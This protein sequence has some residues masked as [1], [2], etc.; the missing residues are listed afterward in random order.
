VEKVH[1][2]AEMLRDCDNTNNDRL[3]RDTSSVL[4]VSEELQRRASLG[5]SDADYLEAR[6]ID[7]LR[8]P[9]TEAAGSSQGRF[10]PNTKRSDVRRAYERLLFELRS[11]EGRANADLAAL[12]HQEL[13]G[14]IDLYAQQKRRMG[15]LDFVDLLLRVRDLLRENESVRA[16]FRSEISH[17]FVDEFQDTDPIQVEIL[18]LLGDTPG[19]L[20][21]VGDPKQ[22]IYRFRRADLGM[23]A[24]VKDRLAAGGAKIE[25]LSTSYRSLPD[26][27]NFVNAAFRRVMKGDG[28]VQQAEYVPLAPH[29]APAEEGRLAGVVALPVPE[30]YGSRG[31]TDEAIEASLPDLVAAFVE[32][33]L[34][35][36][37]A[38]SDICIL[39][40]RFE[41]YGADVTRP[42]VQALEARGIA[43]LLVGG[44]SFHGREEIETIRTALTAVEWPDDELSLYAT[45]RGS[46]FG[47][48]DEELLEYRHR[49]GRL[50]PFSLP[51]DLPERLAMIGDA[52]RFLA[53]LHLDRN[54]RPVADTLRR[55]FHETRCH[56]G[57]V[58]RPSGKQVLANVMQLLEQAR[59]YDESGALSFRGFVESLIE[60]AE[61]GRASE[62][63][64]LEEGSEGVR[65]MTVHKAKGLEFPIVILADITC[66]DTHGSASRYVDADANLAAMSICGMTPVDVIRNEAA[67][68]ERERAE[69][70]R[71]AYVAATRARDLLVVPV[72]ADEKVPGKWL[73]VLNDAIYPSTPPIPRAGFGKDATKRPFDFVD[74]ADTTVR[75]GDY[76]FDGYRV[77]W[78]DSLSLRL[79][80]PIILG[81]PQQEL[82]GR[83]APPG[84]V[85]DDTRAYRGWQAERVET[86]EHSSAPS[87]RLA[88]AI[89]RSQRG[90]GI[91]EIEIVEV[92]RSDREH[93]RRYGTLM[94]AVLAAVDLARPDVRRAAELQARILGAPE[95]EVESVVRAVEALIRHPLIARASKA[96]RVRREVP[97]TL[98]DEGLLVEGVADLAFEED[99]GWTVVDFKTDAELGQRLDSYKRQVALYARSISEA[100]NR[101]AV[102]ILVRV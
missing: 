48:T 100:T 15:A 93:G 56:A 20:F 31:I 18:T 23:Y 98:L 87:I 50:T 12:L 53:A 80:V 17:F 101:P 22:S 81:I 83:N 71:V 5:E 74:R 33:Q 41:K 61:Y 42:Y 16:H 44:K 27:Q 14:A 85:E 30:P 76:L 35:E 90:G 73:S 59:V 99:A 19:K 49:F 2:Y 9:F 45:L 77:T 86:V 64:V 78:W 7:L 13:R 70:V 6:L 72:L 97:V 88:T 34:K 37:A 51:D 11:F 91:P 84:L 60:E 75:P 28:E 21:L 55:L 32:H 67:E 24:G 36:G 58:L 3:Y 38:P 8:R 40:R 102:G 65:L 25:E 47:V 69:A 10:G 43:Q 54:R 29:R 1:A 96:K 92:N 63:P 68:V 62:A 94:H 89:E 66:N 52:L 39:F 82:L 4:R 46:L 79:G 57:F 95:P 26:I